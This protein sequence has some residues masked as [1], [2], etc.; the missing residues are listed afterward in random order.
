[1][2][3]SFLSA[4]AGAANNAARK[5]FAIDEVANLVPAVEA[6][7]DEDG[8]ILEEREPE[9]WA[10][11]VTG[12]PVAATLTLPCL[13]GWEGDAENVR[14]A[15]AVAWAHGVDAREALALWAAS[16]WKQTACVVQ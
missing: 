11:K 8:T 14:H 13:H 5:L 3:T 1:M 9:Y 7:V 2:E 4:E 10:H 16:E 6:A 15:L 12:A